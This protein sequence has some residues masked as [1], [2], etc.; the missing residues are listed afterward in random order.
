MNIFYQPLEELT[1]YNEIVSDI[2]N[3]K[4][5]I[6]VTGVVDGQKSQLM[7]SLG[8][9]FKYKLIIAADEIK[10]KEMYEDY[11]IFDK[12]VYLYPAKDVI[13][14]TADIHGNA[15]IRD[16]LVVLRRLMEGLPTTIISTIECGMDNLLPLDYLRSN[17]STF[18]YW[19]MSILAPPTGIE[20]I[21]NP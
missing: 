6:Q 3:Q 15:I 10:A 1:E 9:D 8:R 20:P 11:R 16:R 19:R 4:F 12:D 18:L 7:S 14:F 17:V 21:T 13:F 5:P 2:K